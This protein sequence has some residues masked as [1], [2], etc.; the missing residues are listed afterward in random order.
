[1]T[2]NE[3][4]DRPR[5]IL[6]KSDREFLGG[7]NQPSSAVGQRKARKRIRE[8]IKNGVLDFMFLWRFLEDRDLEQIFEFSND[9]LRSEV[10]MRK[11][12]SDAIAFLVLSMDETGDNK[13]LRLSHSLCQAGVVNNSP[14]ESLVIKY[15]NERR[16]DYEFPHGF[17][18]L[19]E[20]KDVFKVQ[21]LSGIGYFDRDRLLYDEAI[22]PETFALAFLDFF[23]EEHQEKG[24]EMSIEYLIERVKFERALHKNRERFVTHYP[25]YISD[26]GIVWDRD[27]EVFD[28]EFE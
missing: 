19:E 25:M 7:I 4:V 13:G 21:G 15:P 18:S 9:D 8:R 24:V 28:E 2:D 5:G 16:F 26:T 11:A 3:N 1:M 12:I 20:I 6:T 27:I 10:Q 14:P 17:R 22:D 23:E